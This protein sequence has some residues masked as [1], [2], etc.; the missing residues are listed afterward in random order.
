[1]RISDW[2]SDVCSSDL[3]YMPI[4]AVLVSDAIYQAIADNSANRVSFG[5]GYTSSAHPVAAPVALETL[6]IS[7]ERDLVGPLRAVS[8]RLHEGLRR[9]AGRPLVGAV[10]GIGLLAAGALGADKTTN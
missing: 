8:P 2:S 9:F 1:M 4:S 10:R 5:H 3:A 6:K 7:E